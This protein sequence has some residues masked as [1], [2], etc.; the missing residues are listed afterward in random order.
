MR[1]QR[2]Y[3]EKHV[4]VSNS[5]LTWR[6]KGPRS[7]RDL[8]E[9]LFACKSIPTLQ[10]ISNLLVCITTNLTLSHPLPSPPTPCHKH[11]TPSSQPMASSTFFLNTSV[12]PSTFVSKP[13]KSN[14][15]THFHPTR[16][17]KL[18][19]RGNGN[20]ST[21]RAAASSSS[22]I[23]DFDL[24]ELLGVES[25]SD[26]LQIKKAYRALQKRC[27]PDIA[28]PAGHDMA[29]ILNEVYSLLS[30]PNSRSAYDQVSVSLGFVS[31]FEH[32]CS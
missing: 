5:K 19:G 18:R 13:S 29:I 11:N 20:Y 1:S 26:Q 24:Y 4:D 23:K 8:F 16:T 32:F 10:N 14:P 6:K 15:K 2:V 25:S 21:C 27:H 9:L 17:H 3:F 31:W 28:G 30:D 7:R 12:S 22:W